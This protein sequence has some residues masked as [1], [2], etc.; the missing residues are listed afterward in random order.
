MRYLVEMIR[1]TRFYI[2]ADS[3]DEA[4]DWAATH[5]TFDLDNDENIF[6]YENEY[7]ERIVRSM[8]AETG[9][10]CIKLN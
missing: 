9:E 5:T 4:L 8:K 7:D 10:D 6:D 3:E 2:E 1:S